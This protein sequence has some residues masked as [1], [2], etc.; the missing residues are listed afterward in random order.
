MTAARAIE[1]GERP[2]RAADQRLAEHVPLSL[3]WSPRAFLHGGIV[4]QM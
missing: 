4:T 2:F 3:L 1:S